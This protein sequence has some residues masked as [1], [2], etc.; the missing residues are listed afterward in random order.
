[1]T[2]PP[3][4]LCSLPCITRSGGSWGLSPFL[5]LLA[6]LREAPTWDSTKSPGDTPS[7]SGLFFT[8][9]PAPTSLTRWTQ[10]PHSGRS[11]CPGGGAPA[12]LTGCRTGR[13]WHGSHLQSPAQPPQAP[14]HS[15]NQHKHIHYHCLS[16]TPYCLECRTSIQVPD[17][18]YL[19]E[20]S[21]Q[22]SETP[23]LQRR[24]LRGTGRLENCP[25]SCS[26]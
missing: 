15:S 5:P 1:M 18:Y 21:Q 7:P 22:P 8:L 16:F 17:T 23:V 2:P 10:R 20:S 3:H 6:P 24:E 12:A 14:G 19:T 4:H 9:C 25:Q 13:T 11:Q 26:W